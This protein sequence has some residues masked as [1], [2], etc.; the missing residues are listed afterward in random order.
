MTDLKEFLNK[1]TDKNLRRMI[2]SNARSKEGIS[3]IQVRPVEIKG[4]LVYQATKTLGTK[5]LHENYD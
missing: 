1:Y 4:R 3:K 5:E 2:L